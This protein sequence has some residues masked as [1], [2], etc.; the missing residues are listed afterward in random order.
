LAPMAVRTILCS[1]ID[2]SR[3]FPRRYGP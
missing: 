3:V 1:G 2:P